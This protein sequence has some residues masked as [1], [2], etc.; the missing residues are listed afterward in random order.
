MSKRF[1]TPNIAAWKYVQNKPQKVKS[2]KRKRFGFA[3]V[4]DSKFDKMISD[5]TELV[6]F[7]ISF[8]K[9]VVRISFVLFVLV[10]LYILT[11]TTIS[12]FN[13]GELLFIDTLITESYGMLRDVIAAYIIKAATENSLRIAFSVLSDY[14]D[15]KYDIKVKPNQDEYDYT[16]YTETDIPDI[17]VDD[18]DPGNDSAE[19][20]DQMDGGIDIIEKGTNKA[21]RF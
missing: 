1:F 6:D 12:Y 13:S 16:D 4:D 14:L 10:N 7:A 2:G 17:P 15:K 11:M 8:T 20:E 9:T 18:E 5:S 3:G 19:V 21:R